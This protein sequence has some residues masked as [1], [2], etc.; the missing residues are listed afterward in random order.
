MEQIW[1]FSSSAVTVCAVDFLDPA[2][3][4]EPRA[5]ERGV[6]L[7]VRPV[8]RRPAGS[9]YASPA[10]H[11]EPAI[12]RVDLLESS[13]HAAD[14]MHW[15]PGMRDG[16]PEDRIFDG[17][18][19][20]DPRRWLTNFFSSV[21]DGALD[22]LAPEAVSSLRGDGPAIAAAA[23]DILDC[24]MS[25]LEQSRHLWPDVAHDERGMATA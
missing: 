19:N 11:L 15:H 23:A 25:T 17:T 10:L 9:I 14:R 8:R 6:R 13:P 21:C 4:D 18:M 1:V 24:V 12:V 7:E 16:E 22:G 20:D 3:A 2:A 5:R